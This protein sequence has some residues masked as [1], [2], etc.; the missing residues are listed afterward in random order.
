MNPFYD[1]KVLQRIT[2]PRWLWLFLWMFPTYVALEMERVIYYKC[3]R[4]RI[5]LLKEEVAPWALEE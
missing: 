5:Y 3:V 4:G 2:F 1:P